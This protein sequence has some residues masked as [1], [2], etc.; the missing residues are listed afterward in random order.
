MNK[1]KKSFDCQVYEAIITWV[2]YDVK[3][4]SELFPKLFLSIRLPL[5]QVNDLINI[6]EYEELV[7]SNSICKYFSMC[8]V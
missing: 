2:K 4:R 6:V 3:N 7:S 5:I 8:T 1:I